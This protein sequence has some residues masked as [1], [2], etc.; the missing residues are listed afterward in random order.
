M[1]FL[2][3]KI[4]VLDSGERV[5]LI[6]DS[7]TAIPHLELN[8]YLFNIRKPGLTFKALKKESEALCLIF[9]H[10]EYMFRENGPEAIFQKLNSSRI[11]DLWVKLKK[12]SN[13]EDAADSTH[14]FRWDVFY[15]FIKHFTGDVI[16]KTSFDDPYFK[17]LITKQKILLT[18]IDNLR[19]KTK[20][21][22]LA[23]L[24]KKIVE[25]KKSDPGCI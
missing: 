21:S 15:N 16:Y 25:L 12:K 6:I 10:N 14:M 4:L 7:A 11:Y 8:R 13:G 19:Y 3:T 5:P 2:K 23:G 18:G 20:S 22:R 24:D 1:L 9:N 17:N